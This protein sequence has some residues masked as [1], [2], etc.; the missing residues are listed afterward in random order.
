MTAELGKSSDPAV[1]IPGDPVSI[2]QTGAELRQYGDHLHQAGAGLQRIDTADG[3]RGQ[4]GDAFRAVFHGQP[5]KWLQAGD[6]F[7]SAADALNNYAATLTWA[8][9]QAA[10]AVEQWNS[11]DKQ[12]A[13]DALSSA[14][15]Q[16]ATV[17]RDA[18]GAIGKARDLA[19]PKPGFW[20]QVGDDI[21]G[22]FSGVGQFAEGAGED[23]LT[24]LASVGNAILHDPGSLAETGL[25]L[26]MAVLGAG[27]EVGGFALDLTGIGSVVG[28]P[29]Q[30]VSA[31]AI[32]GGLGMA[33]DGMNTV[34]NDAAGP[35]RVNM[36]SDGGN[37]GGSWGPSNDGAGSIDESEK[38]FN[39]K[40]RQIADTLQSEGK[41]VRA[42][43][44][45]EVDGERRADAEVDG[46][47]T[48]FKSMDPGA[49]PNTVKNQLNSAKGQAS[50]AIL[51][52]RGSGLDENSARE[53][54]QKFLRNNPGRMDN[55][56]IIGDGYD[57]TWP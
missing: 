46:V 25:G 27:G 13:N 22:F 2:Y 49:T 29:V 45:S 11:G 14:R 33:Y 44:E 39:P 17:G 8:Q 54:L 6:A 7:H 53:G 41:S 23:V 31:A 47:P 30:V 5:G 20:S 52:A 15:N 19:P 57:I 4:A 51:D 43:K 3:W 56:R 26:G 35:D 34:L 16:L 48:E 12:S 50:N 28:V 55:I 42:V 1:L 9:D 21:G 38:P 37:G 32:A 40:E 24:S 18:A 10:T 36:G